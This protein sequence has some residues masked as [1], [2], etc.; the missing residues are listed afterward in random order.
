MDPT[1]GKAYPRMRPQELAG[2]GVHEA[3]P[4]R[5]GDVESAT[6]RPPTA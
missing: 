2:K 6:L 1:D 4:V 5:A 3:A